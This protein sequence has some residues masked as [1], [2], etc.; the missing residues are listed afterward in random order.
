M[1]FYSPPHFDI[2][3]TEQNLSPPSSQDDLSDVI[4]WRIRTQHTLQQKKPKFSQPKKQKQQNLIKFTKQVV[5]TNPFIT[6]QL[7][8]S[9]KNNISVRFGY[10]VEVFVPHKNFSVHRCVVTIQ[11]HCTGVD[12]IKLALKQYRKETRQQPLSDDPNAYSLRV[13][14]DDGLPDTD[15]PGM[16]CILCIFFYR[17]KSVG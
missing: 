10:P 4:T 8:Q 11:K 6:S 14:Q 3:T 12:L 17:F 15:W 2:E 1:F 13:A 7:T 5:Q 16:Y 9:L